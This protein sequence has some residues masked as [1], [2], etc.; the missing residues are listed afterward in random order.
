M[1]YKKDIVFDID[2]CN[3]ARLPHPFPGLGRDM[4]HGLCIRVP[5]LRILYQCQGLGFSD[6]SEAVTKSLVMKRWRDE[7]PCL[8][9]R[10]FSEY[11]KYQFY[12]SNDTNIVMWMPSIYQKSW[13]HLAL[14][15]SI[16]DAS[17]I[18]LTQDNILS[19]NDAHGSVSPFLWHA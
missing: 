16:R 12:L 19:S 10:Q 18:N 8:F 1:V 9:A 13:I 14:L 2:G 11:F 7:L 4:L 15:C 3:G 6:M 5:E 17:D